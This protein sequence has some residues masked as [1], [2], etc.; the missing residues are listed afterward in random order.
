[1]N[2]HPPYYKELF[3][4]YG[5][6]N[7]FYQYSYL[8]P[9]SMKNLSPLFKEKAERTARN[10][11]Y[12]FRHINKKKLKHEAEVFR[13]IYNK[14]CVNNSGIR[15][16][17]EED[18]TIL[19]RQLKPI[20]DTR[21]IIFLYHN[22]T[23][24]GFFMQIPEI[25]QIIKHLNGNFSFF[26]KL[27]FLYLLKVKKICTRIM[28]LIFAIIPEYRGLGLESALVMEFAKIAF[29]KNFPY[30]DIDLTWIG[31]FNPLMMR[32]QEQIGGK[33]YKTHATYRLLF[34]EERQKNGFSRC[35]KTGAK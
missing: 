15:E 23:P 2:Y 10:P 19:V 11:E 33:I 6:K 5:F 28:G 8:R 29:S 18:A 32:F 1:M 9:V 4:A 24:V 30:K 34:N 12:H 20:I 26:H 7:Y 27:K 17:N 14:S 35:P 3:E 16:M 22:D 13:E 25:N 21:L 31:D